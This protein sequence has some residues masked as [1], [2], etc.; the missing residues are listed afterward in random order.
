MM[1]AHYTVGHTFT[2]EPTQQIFPEAVSS[3]RDFINDHFGSPYLPSQPNVYG[4]KDNAQEAHEAIRPSNVNVQGV[5][6]P[7]WKETHKGL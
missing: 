3:A 6:Y 4:A 2:C 1:L 5:A 7:I